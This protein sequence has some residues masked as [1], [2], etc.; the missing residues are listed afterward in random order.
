MSS[1]YK[2]KDGLFFK[3]L[4]DGGILISMKKGYTNKE[5][6]VYTINKV[7]KEI[8]NKIDG[9]N[10]V[11]DIT[12]DMSYKYNIPASDIKEDIE[13]LFKEFEKQGLIVEIW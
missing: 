8:W 2:R 4:E 9:I 11:R 6:K 12:L 7:C 3:K 10:S 13:K 1:I 5:S